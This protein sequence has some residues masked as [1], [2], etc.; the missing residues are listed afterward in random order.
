MT[1]KLLRCILP[2]RRAKILKVLFTADQRHGLS[3]H[4]SLIPHTLRTELQRKESAG[5]LTH[6][7]AA[8]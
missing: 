6:R 1:S 4:S 7:D 8:V 3:C 2:C 5:L